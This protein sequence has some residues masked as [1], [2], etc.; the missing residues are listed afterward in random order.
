M[1]CAVLLAAC[2]S[3]GGDEDG[4][5]CDPGSEFCASIPAS[6]FACTD[7]QYWPLVEE[8][9]QRPLSVHYSR[10]ADADEA[11]EVLAILER[12]WAVQVD[13]LGFAAPLGD[14]GEC[15]PDDR[16]DMFL[17]RGADGAFVE[18]IAE[19][20][21]TVHDDFTTYM[22]IDPFGAFGNEFLD[23]TLAHEFNH[24]VQ[25]GDDWWESAL[26]FEMS[27]TFAESLVYPGQDD[28]FYT[29]EDFQRHPEWSL[30]YDDR[31]ETWYMYGASMFLHFLE[32]RH[33]P[34]DQAFIARIWR[35]SRSDPAIGR[36]DYIDAMR[37][38]LGSELGVALDDV[39]VEFMQWRWFVA[40]FDD[41]SHFAQ[42][43]DWPRAVEHQELGLGAG[44]ASLDLEAMIY[45][46]GYVRLVNQGAAERQVAVDL[47]AQA[48]DVEWRLT[49]AAGEEVA[50]SVAVPAGG[51]TVIVATVLPLAEL[52]TETLDF[53]LRA[54]VLELTA[55]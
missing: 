17:W 31:Y 1:A 36:P 37:S 55:L 48:T 33:Y 4:A 38:V 26:I 50:G 53:E 19:N 18:A 24:A 40:G 52:S 44:Q 11:A 10:F 29:L 14:G 8:S 20:P 42:G 39:V 13:D 34:D 16:Y 12:A 54:A 2:G 21:A 15:G 5:A 28:Y 51:S 27:A 6:A 35:A 3:G 49:T 23:T 30:F 22:A 41:G 25:A 32:Q 9:G 7:A 43:A 47:L 45:G 46:A